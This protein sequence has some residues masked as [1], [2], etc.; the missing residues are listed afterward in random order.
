MQAGFES[1]S[2]EVTKGISEQAQSAETVKEL[3]GRIRKFMS[4][5]FHSA[6]SEALTQVEAEI[7]GTVVCDGSTPGY[8][9]FA[10]KVKVRARPAVGQWVIL[11]CYHPLI[12]SHYP[13]P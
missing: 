13:V 3:L 2:Q 11:Y 12:I 1:P 7:N 9:K 10:E 6:L 5:D 8:K 4:P